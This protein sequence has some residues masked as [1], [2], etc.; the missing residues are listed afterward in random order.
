MSLGHTA[1]NSHGTSGTMPYVDIVGF[2]HV[3]LAMPAG[4][5]ADAERFYAGVLGLTRI[6][7]PEVLAGRG[8]C[9]FAN[10][11]LQVHLGVEAE[12]RPA[13]KAH[14]ALVVNDRD[15]LIARLEQHGFDVVFGADMGGYDQA[16]CHDPFGNRIEL[17]PLSPGWQAGP[18][19]GES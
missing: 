17:V 12:F 14:P 6:P 7:K 4:S 3:Q 9:W 13:R 15:G 8:G 2:D 18:R 11:F 5:E 16:F 1:A 19:H 10:R